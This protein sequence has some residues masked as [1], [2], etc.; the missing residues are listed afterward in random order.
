LLTDPKK[1]TD[2]K[3]Y[4]EIPAV[5]GSSAMCTTVLLDMRLLSTSERS[6]KHEQAESF[7]GNS[8]FLSAFLL[9][10]PIAFLGIDSTTFTTLGSW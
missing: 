4:M 1:N 2:Y 10:L 9:I 5:A 3:L 8:S 7:E 6:H